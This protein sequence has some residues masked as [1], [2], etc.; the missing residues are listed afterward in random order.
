MFLK[1]L[2]KKKIFCVKKLKIRTNIFQHFNIFRNIFNI[3]HFSTFF[4]IYQH[5]STFC[6]KF[7]TFSIHF[8]INFQHFSTFSNIFNKYQ[9]FFHFE[10]CLQKV[11]HFY[12]VLILF[13]KEIIVIFW[14][15]ENQLYI[16]IIQI[17]IKFRI[18][19]ALP[20]FFEF[21]WFNELIFLKYV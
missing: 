16:F 6:S 20:L 8:T 17:R 19:N 13:P 3:Q 1:S 14:F 10:K 15:V 11:Q 2:F 12:Y 5:F 18:Y 9:H 4:N 7:S 21:F